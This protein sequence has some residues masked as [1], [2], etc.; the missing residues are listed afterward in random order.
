M[1]VYLYTI[2]DCF[3]EHVG[4]VEHFNLLLGILACV[5]CLMGIESVSYGAA[6]S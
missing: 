3:T 4:L 5:S 2:I 1:R 6:R